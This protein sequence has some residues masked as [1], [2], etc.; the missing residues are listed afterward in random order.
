MLP[1]PLFRSKQFSS[2]NL[3]TL[4]FY[5][6]FVAGVTLATIRLQTAMGYTALEAALASFPVN[7]LMFFLAGRFGGWSHRV[8]PKVPMTV[9]PLIVALGLLALSRIGPGTDYWLY[10]LPSMVVWGLG[11]SMTVAP[12]TAAALSAVESSRAGVA[13]AFNNAASRVGQSVGITLI[14][15]AAGMG[16]AASLGGEA[17]QQNYGTALLIAAAFSALAAVIAAVF[18]PRFSKLQQPSD[19]A[20]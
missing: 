13:S 6:A 15:L 9:G 17:F 12:L 8:G 18:V 19:V 7:I 4:V 14:P 5:G 1:L 11:L 3:C 2:V 10:V 16:G 20:A